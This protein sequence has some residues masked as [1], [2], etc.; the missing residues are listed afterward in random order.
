[1]ILLE[2]RPCRITHGVFQKPV[3]D[4]CC[5][6]NLCIGT[7]IYI[8]VHV[9][10]CTYAWYPACMPVCNGHFLVHPFP[11]VWI[12]APVHQV[13]LVVYLTAAWRYTYIM[14]DYLF[15]AFTVYTLLQVCL[16]LWL[17]GP[18]LQGLPKVFLSVNG[19]G[20]ATIYAQPGCISVLMVFMN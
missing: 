6:R 20:W 16:I 11:S 17:V 18:G 8:Q 7:C 2:A 3:Q 13:S 12:N 9:Y 15:S 10:I 5:E 19:E 4:G 1:M 14:L